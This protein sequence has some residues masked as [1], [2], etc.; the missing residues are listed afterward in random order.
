MPEQEQVLARFKAAGTGILTKRRICAGKPYTL[1]NDQ[2]G[3]GGG[4]QYHITAKDRIN[5]EKGPI[6]ELTSP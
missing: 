2:Y 4:T 5:I 1:A 6:M 3:Q